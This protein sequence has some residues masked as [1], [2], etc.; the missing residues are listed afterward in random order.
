MDLNGVPNSLK[1]VVPFLRLAQNYENRDKFITYNCK[2][3]AFQLAIKNG[4]SSS[5]EKTFI[6]SQLAKLEKDKELLM[7]N[8]EFAEFFSNKLAGSSYLENHAQTILDWCDNQIDNNSVNKSVVKGYYTCGLLFELIDELEQN[9]HD[10]KQKK[11]YSKYRA[12]ITNKALITGNLSILQQSDKSEETYCNKEGFFSLQKDVDNFSFD[13]TSTSN[14]FLHN[15]TNHNNNHHNFSYFDNNKDNMRST[16][17]VTPS[18]YETAYTSSNITTKVSD[19]T[20]KQVQK[21]CKSIVSAL[22]FEDVPTAIKILKESID[23]LER[24]PL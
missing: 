2:I 18:Y 22:N 4:L 1:Y 15:A 9:S 7:K 12:S 21:N 24:A 8:N 11:I 19:F 20:I 6:G 17:T 14:L 23:L 13:Q 16:S 10:I 5:E 3:H